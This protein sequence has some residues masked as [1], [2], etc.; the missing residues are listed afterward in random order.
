MSKKYN[1]AY[2]AAARKIINQAAAL[3]CHTTE[4]GRIFIASGY[5]CFA[6][7][8]DDYDNLV[9]PV[10]NCDPGNWA[11][12]A[13]GKREETHDLEKIFADAVK[14]SLD[15]VA[16]DA[17]PMVFH[18]GRNQ[19]MAGFYHPEKDFAAFYNADYI[20]AV[21]DLALFRAP[22]P[23]SPAVAFIGPDP[24]ALIM[25]IKP[26]P[27]N[28]RAVCAYF[29]ENSKM[30]ELKAQLKDKEQELSNAMELAEALTAQVLE[31]KEK[32]AAREA[33]EAA[34]AA[35]L[36]LPAPTPAAMAE[37]IAARWSQMDGITAT[38]KGAK[39]A[40]PIVWLSGAVEAHAEAIAANGGRWS[41]KRSAY[42]FRVA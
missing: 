19:K 41:G 34:R 6:L 21:S 23:V 42:Y 27:E 15:H 8:A 20:A 29:R 9:R 38:V 17:A 28:T 3:H 2:T 37:S 35:I 30:T 16:L 39:T 26:K 7:T 36:A 14:A 1:G 18:M 4:D 25:P 13:V 32:A 24:V 11:I 5:W 12:D 33:Q 10:S 22:S 31:L 40:T